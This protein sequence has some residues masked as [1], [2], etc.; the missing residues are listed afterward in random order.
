MKAICDRAALVES[1]NLV[2]GV[3][4]SRTPKPVLRCV[5]LTADATAPALTLSATDLEIF[6]R[7]QTPRVE[8][9]EPGEA[10][11]PADTLSQIVRESVDPTLALETEQ[12]ATH[13]RGQ[14]SH[15]KVFGSAP[16]EFPPLPEFEDPAD[17]EITSGTLTQLIQ[18]TTFASARENSR[19]AM[20]GVLMEREGSKLCLVATDG[21]RLAVARGDCAAA[22]SDDTSTKTA[23]VPTKAL[24][25]LG[26]LLGADPDQ[27]VRVRVAGNQILLA[28]ATTVLASNLV[29][30]NFPPYRDVI[31][32]DGD[33]K[34][35]LATDVLASAV[36][37]AALLTNEESKGVRFSF[38]AE[39]LT[40]TSRAA[41]M[42]EAQIGVEC[43][44]Y[45]GDPIEIGF[46]PQYI[47]DAL[48]VVDASEIQLDMK[49]AGKPGVIRTGP[50]F[51]Y[52]VMPV[53]LQ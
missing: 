42:G 44:G 21:H 27:T 19:Y 39:G 45:Q 53:N 35:T 40:L 33:K 51:E 37:R 49:A 11:I 1:L 3:V 48:K 12:D 18:Q 14:D 23:I 16:E 17:F 25:L 2:S 22:R 34:A 6:V 52:V 5:K 46:N 50:Q 24:V 9:S 7:T 31:P 41:E 26:R 15:F 4:V 36:R 13:I 30:G 28:T 32:R 8:V 10:L 29:E 47:L 43:P 20:N 38:T